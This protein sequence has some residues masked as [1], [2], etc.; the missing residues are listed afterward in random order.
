[1]AQATKSSLDTL[2]QLCEERQL[3]S[4]A[5]GLREQFPDSKS[6]PPRDFLEIVRDAIVKEDK[7]QRHQQQRKSGGKPL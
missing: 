4:L 2:L 3:T 6:A 7:R 1:M 5:K